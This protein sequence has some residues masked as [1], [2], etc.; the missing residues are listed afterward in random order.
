MA[1]SPGCSGGLKQRLSSTLA[2]C[3]PL[4]GRPA[5]R[6]DGAAF[7]RLRIDRR[8][9]NLCR[10]LKRGEALAGLQVLFVGQTPATRLEE[11][12]T[13]AKAQPLLVVTDAADRVPE[14]SV[15]N[16]VPV[17]NKLRFDIAL[18]AAERMQLRISARLLAVARR[19]VPG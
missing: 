15:I 13:S 17:D 12:L 8:T 18:A 11:I 5:Q 14:G 1:N 19:V 16:F 6:A 4:R 3:W 7:G 10:R 2:S 9:K